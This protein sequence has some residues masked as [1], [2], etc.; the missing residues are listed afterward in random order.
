MN[1]KEK[2]NKLSLRENLNNCFFAIQIIFR[3]SKIYGCSIIIEAIRH[4]LVN[5]LEQTICVYLVLST[6]EKHKSYS[7]ILVVVGVFLVVDFIAAIL[8]NLYEHKFKPKYLPIIQ[9]KMKLMLYEKAKE[10]DIAYYDNV[11]YYNDYVLVASEADGIV[12]RAEQMVRMFFGSITIFLCY[13]SFFLSQ[14]AISFLFVM[15]SFVLRTFF[16]NKLNKL[17]YQVRIDSNAMERK[18][19]YLRRVFYLKDYAQ[20]L[21]LNKEFKNVLHKEFDDVNEEI[22]ELNKKVGPKKVL[23]SFIANYLATDFVLDIIY[24]LYLIIRC[25]IFHKISFSSVI[26]LYNSANSL[27]RGLSTVADLG[28]FMIETSMY[29]NK[30]KAFLNIVVNQGK[31][32]LKPSLEP[33]TIE[34]RNVSFGYNK[35]RMILKNINLTIHSEEKVALV[36]FNGAGKSTLIKLLLRLYEPNEGEILLNGVNI[37]S[38]DQEEYRKYIGIVFQDFQLFAATI[39]ENITMDVVKEKEEDNVVEAIK[40]SGFYDRFKVLPEGLSTQLTRE[41]YDAGTN[42]SGGEEQR[43]ALARSYYKKTGLVLLDEPS[44]AL[45]PI[46]EYSMNQS[47]FEMAQGKSVVF[48]SHRLSTTRKADRIY[49]MKNGEIIEEGTHK[50][51]LEQSGIYHQMWVT[52]AGKYFDLN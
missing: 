3:S 34:C 37:Q 25:L 45:D 52:Q 18:R 40:K 38:F 24:V 2:K 28:T 46:A 13:G 5:F 51:L 21:R 44:S 10:V 49:V 7:N 17:N 43:I 20:E 30:I 22:Y 19:N 42:F 8:C 26:V 29:V 27:R 36:G 48:I 32:K 31:G 16:N 47:L 11:E 50:E 6:I 14:D 35:E 33:A 41:F 1:E 4:H 12:D 9:Q 23:L 15:L 39:H